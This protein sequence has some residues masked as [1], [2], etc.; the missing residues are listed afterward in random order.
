[1]GGFQVWLLL[2]G[3]GFLICKL[4]AGMGQKT[5]SLRPLRPGFY[6]WL[7][8]VGLGLDGLPHGLALSSHS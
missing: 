6:L 1:M 2:S 7:Q 5:L 3:L 4:D 8:E